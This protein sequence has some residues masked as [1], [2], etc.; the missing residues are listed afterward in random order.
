APVTLREDRI[1][2]LGGWLP[3][4]TARLRTMTS[5]RWSPEV[6]STLSQPCFQPRTPAQSRPVTAAGCWHPRGWG[7][8]L[9]CEKSFPGR[10]VRPGPTVSMVAVVLLVEVPDL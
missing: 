4:S 8:T 5:R 6:L 1:H 9:T 10:T 2:A 3:S 7:S